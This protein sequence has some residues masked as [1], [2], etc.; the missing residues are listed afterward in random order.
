MVEEERFYT[1]IGI[2]QFC[3]FWIHKKLLTYNG[4]Q[5]F[6]SEHIY[7]SMKYDYVGASS[8]TLKYAEEIRKVSTANKAYYLG[9]MTQHPSNW[10][11][12]VLLNR[13][14]EK[15]RNLGVIMRPDWKDVREDIMYSCLYAKFTQ[16]L[17]C[18]R[19]LLSTGNKKLIEETK[20]DS[21][22]GNGGDDTGQNRLGILLMKLRTE[23]R[24][25]L[26]DQ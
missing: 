9:R 5:Y 8:H 21:Y 22:W 4:K 17:E 12:K 18:Q 7:Q 2:R 13:I 1:D 14:I 16:D 3:N 6:S 20:R 19:L 11:W 25:S 23:L 15:Y 24:L 26:E 10:P